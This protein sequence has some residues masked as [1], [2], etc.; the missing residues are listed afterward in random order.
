M[1]QKSSRVKVELWWQK[2]VVQKYEAVYISAFERLAVRKKSM[3]T[4]L[5][6]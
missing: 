5:I 3:K 6:T 4:Y 2:Y 1:L